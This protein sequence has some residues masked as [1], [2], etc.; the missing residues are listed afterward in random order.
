MGLYAGSS[1]RFNAYSL[2]IVCDSQAV[3]KHNL[4]F[5]LFLKQ[6]H[7]LARHRVW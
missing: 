4:L 3:S 6:P 2:P 7:L 5:G 1:T